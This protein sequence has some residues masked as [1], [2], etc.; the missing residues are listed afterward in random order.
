MFF[1][2]W[3][4][5]FYGDIQNSMAV[6]NILRD[7]GIQYKE[8]VENQAIRMGLSPGITTSRDYIKTYVEI[9]VLKEQA[10]LASSILSTAN[11]KKL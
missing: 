3:I 6:K 8:K 5:V 2:K 11:F 9:Q 7:H 10:S 4:T 1:H